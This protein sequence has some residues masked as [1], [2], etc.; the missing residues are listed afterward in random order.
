MK[1]F[2]ILAFAF[3]VSLANA[4]TPLIAHKS[5]SGN[6]ASFFTDPSSNFG[7]IRIDI[8]KYQVEPVINTT[9]RFTPLNDSTIIRE[10][11]TYNQHVI[12]VDTLPNKEKYSAT[13]FQYKYQDSIRKEEMRIQREK[14][15]DENEYIKREDEKQKLLEWE[16][17]QQQLKHQDE[18]KPRKKKSYLLFLFGVTGGGMLFMRLFRSSK[19]IQRSIS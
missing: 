15:E 16:Q 9:E 14:L 7:A 1:F 13:L 3:S 5:H 8:E 18:P 2:N 10:V 6:A 4:Q 12:L 17:Q 19:S 11:T